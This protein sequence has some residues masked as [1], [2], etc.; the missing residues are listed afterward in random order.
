MKIWS[1]KPAEVALLRGEPD[2]DALKLTTSQ[3][4]EPYADPPARRMDP[5]TVSGAL[6]LLDALGWSAALAVV[7]SLNDNAS[8]LAAV[9]FGLLAAIVERARGV[10]DLTRRLAARTIIIGVTAAFVIGSAI[11]LLGDAESQAPW[12]WS[13]VAAAIAIAVLRILISALRSL[14]RGS[15]SVCRTIAVIGLPSALRNRLVDEIDSQRYFRLI[16]VCEPADASR[17]LDLAARD[18]IDEVILVTDDETTPL[19]G[20][21]A[22]L[23]TR[24][25]SVAL[26]QPVPH[27]PVARSRRSRL[28]REDLVWLQRQKQR[29]WPLYVKRTIDVC[30]ALAALVLLS[31]FLLL[32]AVAIRLESEGPAL[33]RQTRFG[34]AGRPFM[35][36]KFRSMKHASADPSGSALTT[37]GDARVTRIGAFIRATSIDELPQLVNILLGD[38]SF[39]GPRPHPA[40]AKAGAVL[41][42]VLIPNFQAR[43]RVRPGLTGLAQSHGL[44]G[45]TDTEKKLLDRFEKDM[46]YVESWSIMLDLRILLK[47]VHHMLQPENAY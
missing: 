22:A 19:A 42:D 13:G 44:R 26:L 2:E 5:E 33:F 35:I 36:W 11:G 17:V 41:Y 47:T 23:E 32:V 25:V 20:S 3:F 4:A 15:E 7:W 24:P 10:H 39:V 28:A 21:V 46:E 16:A 8:M 34:F 6:T 18:A 30:G 14:A 9:A 45:N 37:R 43:Y 40:G 29:G 12:W 38:L 31:P 1:T 27:G